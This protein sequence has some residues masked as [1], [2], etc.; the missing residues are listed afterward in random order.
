MW[1]E[2]S[3]KLK[4]L[5]LTVDKVQEAYDYE[6]ANLAGTP[7]VSI[8]ASDN[9]SDYATTT[10]NQR[11]YAFDIRCFVKRANPV[12]DRNAEIATRQLVDAVLNKLD[13]N[14]QLSGIVNTS[15]HEFLFMRA[16]P[17]AWGYAGR[18]DEYRVAEIKVKCHVYVDTTVIT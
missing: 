2:L 1:D 8:T 9:E 4:T 17:S 6:E 14:Y 3:A 10:E 15:G 13:K 5:I 12:S 18:E 16:A 11:I 7:A